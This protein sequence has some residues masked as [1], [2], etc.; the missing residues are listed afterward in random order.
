MI[1]VD[2]VV[3]DSQFSRGEGMPHHGWALGHL[4]KQQGQSGGRGV[5]VGVGATAFTVV[6]S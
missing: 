2:K 1:T 4:G 6:S 5:G 3:G